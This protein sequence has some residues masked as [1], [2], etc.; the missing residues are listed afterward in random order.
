MFATFITYKASPLSQVC[1]G[2]NLRKGRAGG[3]WWG[4]RTGRERQLTHSEGA[5]GPRLHWQVAWQWGWPFGGVHTVVRGGAVILRYKK[6]R[7]R[8]APRRGRVLGEVTISGWGD[9]CRGLSCEPPAAE[10]PH[11]G[12]HSRHDTLCFLL[13]SAC[14]CMCVCVC[15]LPRNNKEKKKITQKTH[16]QRTWIDSSQK[17]NYKCPWNI[18]KDAWFYSQKKCNLQIY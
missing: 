4:S 2:E 14:V 12:T 6:A 11:L 9:A 15:V 7:D 18:W 5:T 1:S 10:A 3:G 16:R 8:G 13:C 17:K